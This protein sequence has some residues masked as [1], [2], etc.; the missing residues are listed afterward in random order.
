MS[1]PSS[2][3]QE[4]MSVRRLPVMALLVAI[5]ML[6]I[7][8]FMTFIA[9]L[10]IGTLHVP[11]SALP[12]SVFRGLPS[13]WIT[14]VGWTFGAIS[15]FVLGIALMRKI[16]WARRGAMAAIA[17]VMLIEVAR[18]VTLTL[19]FTRSLQDFH[20]PILSLTVWTFLFGTIML[21][22]L[23][24]NDMKSAYDHLNGDT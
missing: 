3:M 17:F 23:H 10:S 7:A 5:T 1:I 9:A 6:L 12:A 4:N 14:A 13:F 18:V 11:T 20:Y 19:L 24:R 22:L 8:V 2:P 15:F 16:P 21:L